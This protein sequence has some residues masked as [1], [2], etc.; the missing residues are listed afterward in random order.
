MK[1]IK[2]KIE[3][4]FENSRNDSEILDGIYSLFGAGEAPSFIGDRPFCGSEL[5]RYIADKFQAYDYRH[6][7][8]AFPGGL[9]FAKGFR[10]SKYL[11]GWQV[12]AST[13]YGTR[14]REP[15]FD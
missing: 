11:D 9:W 8:R 3:T 4:I 6:Y 15:C 1:E 7:P 10:E 5:Y 14:A 2:G 13:G 12:S